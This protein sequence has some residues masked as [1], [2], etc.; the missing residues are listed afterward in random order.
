MDRAHGAESA[1]TDDRDYTERL[2]EL[3]GAWWKRALDVQAPVRWHLRRLALGFT[4]DIGCGIGRNLQ[5]LSGVGVDHNTHSLEVARG[6]GMTVFTPEEFDRSE[7]HR[8]GR[9]DSLLLSHVAEHMRKP[10]A[11]E[12]LRRYVPLLKAGGRCVIMTPQEAGHAA[13]ASHVEF[14]DFAAL[15]SIAAS[16]G[17]A[18]RREYSFPLPRLAGRFF[19]YNEFV[20]VSEK[21]A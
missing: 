14:M 20:S 17:L 10:E 16:C 6:R 19:R 12:L 2:L 15:R 5:H 21:P 11:E 18:P 13:E 4:L 8:P 9:F 3:E 7:F 1:R